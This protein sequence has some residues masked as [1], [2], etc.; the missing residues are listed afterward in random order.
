MPFSI[1]RCGLEYTYTTGEKGDIVC[2]MPVIAAGLPVK[3][4]CR[5]L[6]A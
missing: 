5:L 1:F 4:G 6:E 2:N 3:S